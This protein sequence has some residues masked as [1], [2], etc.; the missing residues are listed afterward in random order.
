MGSEFQAIRFRVSGLRFRVS[1]FGIRVSV[2]G[3][4]VSGLGFGVSGLGFRVSGLEID[5]H[6]IRVVRLFRRLQGRPACCGEKAVHSK[7][8]MN[9]QEVDQLS[10][11]NELINF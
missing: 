10:R 8:L 7:Q 1:G 11:G 6:R 4:R 5:R 9:F 3:F 2:F